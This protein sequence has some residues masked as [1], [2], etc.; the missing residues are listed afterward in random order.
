MNYLRKSYS[1]IIHNI[2][3]DSI[4]LLTFRVVLSYAYVTRTLSF[5]MTSSNGNVFRV[6]G[7][8]KGNPPITGEFSSQRPVTRSFDVY[9]DLHL[10]KR[11][12]KQSRHRWFQ[13]TSRSL[14]RYC[15]VLCTRQFK[16]LRP[17]AAYM[18]HQINPHWF[19]SW[20]VAWPVPIHYLTQCWNVIN[21]AL[22]NKF[23]WNLN[24]CST[25]FIQV[26]AFENV[27]CNASSV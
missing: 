17:I 5:M 12:S 27:V 19:R 25:I 2:R 6:T 4:V 3:N 13:T 20:L 1:R 14:W 9:F 7:N 15:N 26:N 16:S 23:Q 22:G 11:L 24:Q 10:K 18:P 21:W 8:C